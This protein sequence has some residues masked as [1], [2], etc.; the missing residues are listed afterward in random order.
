MRRKR[1][2]GYL[3]SALSFF[4][5]AQS[6]KIREIAGAVKETEPEKRKKYRRGLRGERERESERERR[7]SN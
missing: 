4:L 6:T 3:V 7:G 1:S 2:T 5:D